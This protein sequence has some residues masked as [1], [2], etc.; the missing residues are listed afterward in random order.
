MT[1]LASAIMVVILC[2]SA[3]AHEGA[4][5]IVKERMDAMKA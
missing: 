3:P 2:V 4:T 1:R 5:G